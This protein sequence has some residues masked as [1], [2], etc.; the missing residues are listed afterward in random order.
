[1]VLRCLAYKNVIYLKGTF[2]KQGF[3]VVF[4][5][6]F[7]HGMM[8]ELDLVHVMLKMVQWEMSNM[9]RSQMDVQMCAEDTHF[10]QSKSRVRVSL[11]GEEKK[12]KD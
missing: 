2:Q 12:S 7:C 4:V 3:L 1:M 5:I 8:H 11:D 10:G 9:S 6:G